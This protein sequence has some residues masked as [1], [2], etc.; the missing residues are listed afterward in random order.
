MKTMVQI[1][2]KGNKTPRGKSRKNEIEKNGY[3]GIVRKDEC[4]AYSKSGIKN[5]WGSRNSRTNKKPHKK[6]YKILYYSALQ[7]L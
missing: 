2:T 6:G 7:T 3:T 4:T 1:E 5:Q